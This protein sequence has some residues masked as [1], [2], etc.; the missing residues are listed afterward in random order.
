MPFS[1]DRQLIKTAIV[2]ESVKMEKICQGGRCKAAYSKKKG[3]PPPVAGTMAAK[4]WTGLTL[5]EASNRIT[6]WYEANPDRP[7]IFR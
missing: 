5:H 3:T 2:S 6:R 1:H 7:R 4:A